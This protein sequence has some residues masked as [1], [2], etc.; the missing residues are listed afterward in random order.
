MIA[1]LLI[2]FCQPESEC[3]DGDWLEVELDVPNAGKLGAY[4]EEIGIVW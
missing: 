1:L 3:G 2:L 4:T